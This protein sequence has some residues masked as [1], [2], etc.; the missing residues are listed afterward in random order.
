MDSEGGGTSG[1]A[2]PRG[3]TRGGADPPRDDPGVVVEGNGE[4]GR[5]P[6]GTGPHPKEAGAPTGA[7]ITQRRNA[8][9][10]PGFARWLSACEEIGLCGSQPYH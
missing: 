9:G 2:P 1:I 6:R 8:Q 5:P 7:Q 10:R 4:P 3:G